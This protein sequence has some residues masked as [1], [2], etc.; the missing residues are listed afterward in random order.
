MKL[1]VIHPIQRLFLLVLLFLQSNNILYTQDL[2]DFK[3]TQTYA[4]SLMRAQKFD[5]ASLEYQRLVFM[6][7][8]NDTFKIQL[9]RSYRLGKNTNAGVLQWQE[10]AMAKSPEINIEY[11]KTLVVAGKT[12]DAI[13]FCSLPGSVPLQNGEEIKLYS[14]LLNQ[15]WKTVATVLA[16]WPESMPLPNKM[17]ISSLLERSKSMPYKKPWVA[18]SL[19]AVLP[20]AGKGYTGDWADGAI[21]LVFVGLN[22]WQSWRRFDRE[23]VSSPWG[24]VHGGF[25]LG[26]YLGNVYG[27][28]KAARKFNQRYRHKLLHETENIVFPALD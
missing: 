1:C 13:A 23:G 18:A 27:S 22:A 8:A 28:H 6:V 4:K 7:P 21:G 16:N 14:H 2:Y 20:G 3:H 9:L 11:A 5:Q 12:S 15:D 17:A 26:F 25:A 24:W 10:W 19:S